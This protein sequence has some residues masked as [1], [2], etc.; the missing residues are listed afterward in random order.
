MTLVVIFAFYDIITKSST[1]VTRIELKAAID[2]Y[3]TEYGKYLPD[4]VRTKSSYQNYREFILKV[5]ECKRDEE[6]KPFDRDTARQ[7]ANE[8]YDAGGARKLGMK[9]IIPTD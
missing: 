7:Y 2:C 9:S 6:N 3:L 1:L 5:L 8:L 4:L